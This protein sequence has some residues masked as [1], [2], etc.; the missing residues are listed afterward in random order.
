MLYICQKPATKHG[1]PDTAAVSKTA[2]ATQVNE[3]ESIWMIMPVCYRVRSV[4]C[5]TVLHYHCLLMFI[6]HQEEDDEDEQEEKV[7]ESQPEVN[8]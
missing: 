7:D 5:R 8:H 4:L 3:L 1:K 2:D 6:K